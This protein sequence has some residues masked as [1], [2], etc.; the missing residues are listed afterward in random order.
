M[1]ASKNK[2]TITLVKT[3]NRIIATGDVNAGLKVHPGREHLIYPLGNTVIIEHVT[4][5]EFSQLS[6]HTNNVSC[7]AV[8]PSGNY[9]ASGQV[10]HMGFKANVIIWDFHRKQQIATLSLHKVKVQDLAFSPNEK[11]LVTLGGQDDGR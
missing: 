9:L 4:T 10:T 2:L 11:Y 7:I 5:K 1:G 6:G 3:I 8:S